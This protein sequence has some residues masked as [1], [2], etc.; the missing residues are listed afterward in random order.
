[1]RFLHTSDWHLGQDFHKFD[2]AHEHRQFLAW[3]TDTLVDTRTDVLLIAGDVFDVANPP[4]FAQRMFFEFIVE[5][6]R[7]CPHLQTIVIAGNHDSGARLEAP[8]EL[9]KGYGTTVVG[10]VTSASSGLAAGENFIM[11]LYSA[12]VAEKP[13]ALCLGLPFFKNAD[14]QW[15]EK[16]CAYT[17]AV[18]RAYRQAITEARQRYGTEI[19]LIGMG[20]LHARGGT[21]SLDSERRLVI[22]GEEAVPLQELAQEFSYIALGHLHLAQKVGECE[23]VRYSGSPLP[24]SFSEL[25]YPHQVVLGELKDDN[26][27]A[28]EVLRIKRPVDLL[29]VPAKPMPVED[30]LAALAQLELPTLPVPEQPYLEVP[31]LLTGPVPDLRHRIETVLK[32]KPVRLAKISPA[33][34]GASVESRGE[35]QEDADRPTLAGLDSLRKLDPLAV[36]RDLHARKY[37]QSPDDELGR[38]F[39]EIM[40]DVSGE[41][42]A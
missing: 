32:G 5:T 1:M 40:R 2:R 9:L 31:V 25:N 4:A 7:R 18:L 35:R 6:R 3:L 33:R 20:H 11:P 39:E 38:L 21:S 16:S 19:P 17:D 27:V 8:A 30:V 14:L 42:E 41:V 37:G 26:S 29:R 12:G 10:R 34:P 36:F 28:L 22:G 24:M 13:R 15:S 23:N